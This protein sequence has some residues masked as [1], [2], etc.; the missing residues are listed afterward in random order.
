M[1]AKPAKVTEFTTETIDARLLLKVLS[2][3]RK[4]DFTTRLPSEQ[5][6]L[7]GKIYDA[8]NEVI[9]LNERM[10]KEFDRVANVVGKEGRIKQ[11]ASLSMA[12][13]S[14]GACIDS[15]NTLIADLVQPTT[16]V[17]ASSELWRKA[18]SRK[19][20]PSKSKAGADRRIPEN[21]QIVNT[22]V[23]QLST[24]ASK[25]P[26]AREVGTR[27]TRWTGTGERRALYLKDS[28][29]T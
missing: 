25:S 23:D 18:I 3:F 14:W 26:V 24:F 10:A 16:E 12:T 21:C 20:W 6:G 2:D 9:D 15:V 1:K 19:P 17:P 5:T 29:T 8:L 11:R 28:P 13:G 27:K 4:G 7:T 22:M